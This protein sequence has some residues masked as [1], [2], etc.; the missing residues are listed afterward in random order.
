MLEQ[1]LDIN[2]H[3]KEYY[4]CFEKFFSFV[5]KGDF[6]SF[7]ACTSFLQWFCTAI[8]LCIHA[9]KNAVPY[10]RNKLDFI[11]DCLKNI[12]WFFISKVTKQTKEKQPRFFFVLKHFFCFSLHD[13]QE[14]SLIFQVKIQMDQTFY[15]INF[16]VFKIMIIFDR[17]TSI[18]SKFNSKGLAIKKR[19]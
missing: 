5:F 19:D 6:F 11:V 10:K 15:F 13:M 12:A 18:A 3:P 14:T 1:G 2:K 9:S 16:A 17:I 4:I 8:N 7:C